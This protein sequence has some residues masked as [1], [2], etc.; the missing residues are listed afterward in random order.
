M[1]SINWK[2]RETIAKYF[3]ISEQNNAVWNRHLQAIHNPQR[4]SYDPTITASADYMRAMC[5]LRNEREEEIDNLQS[6]LE[7]VK[8]QRDAWEYEKR[9]M[10]IG[11]TD[12]KHNLP[13]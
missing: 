10:R 5:N 9:N 12:S 13:K 4:A 7:E 1:T 3:P 2:I 8:K 6:V 11:M